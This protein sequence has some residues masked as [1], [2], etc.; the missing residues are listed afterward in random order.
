MP[1]EVRAA[2]RD[3]CDANWD[4]APMAE[5]LRELKVRAGGRRGRRVD[6]EGAGAWLRLIR[7]SYLSLI[8][9]REHVRRSVAEGDGE[10]AGSTV[11]GWRLTVDG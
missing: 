7:S 11:G 9:K 2:A 3:M 5:R 4:C 1:P 10:G 6:E 8:R